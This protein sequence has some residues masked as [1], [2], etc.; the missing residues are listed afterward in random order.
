MTAPYL[1]ELAEWLPANDVPARPLIALSTISPDGYPDTRHVLLSEYTDER[2]SFHTDARSRKLAQLEFAPRASFAVAWPELGRQL[3]VVGD[4]EAVTDEEAQRV[5]QHRSYYLQV[6]AWLNDAE[7]AAL[8]LAERQR[9]WA[10][11]EAEHPVG[12]L[13]PPPTWAGTAIRPR[14]VTLWHGRPDAASRRTEYTRADDGTWL[15]T[16]LPG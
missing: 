7:Y 11:F 6:L 9:I 16:I 1:D 13:T 14:R 12:T 3:I 15:T 10:E 4:V 5:Y 8:P 2:F